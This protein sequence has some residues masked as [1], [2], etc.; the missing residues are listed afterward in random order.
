[1]RA[2]PVTTVDNLAEYTGRFGSDELAN[3]MEDPGS[4]TATSSRGPW[5]ARRGGA[6]FTLVARDLFAMED[7]GSRFERDGHGKISAARRCPT[8][9]RARWW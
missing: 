1:M 3:D 7:E 8:I 4:R 9:G 2:T 5:A 6:P